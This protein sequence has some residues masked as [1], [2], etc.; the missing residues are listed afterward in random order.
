MSHEKTQVRL[1]S[2]VLAF[3]FERTC[4]LSKT[5]LRLSS[6]AL[7]FQVKRKGVFLYVVV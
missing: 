3:C 4:V 7:T 5:S 1:E 2:N 6:N